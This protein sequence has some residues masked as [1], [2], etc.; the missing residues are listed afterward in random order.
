MRHH[1]EVNSKGNQH[2]KDSHNEQIDE[3]RSSEANEEH[4]D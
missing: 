4:Y 3:A 2:S 1:N